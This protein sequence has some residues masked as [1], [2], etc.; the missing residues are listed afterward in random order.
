MET[1][2]AVFIAG[3]LNSYTGNILGKVTLPCRPGCPV[4]YRVFSSILGCFCLTSASNTAPQFW[5]LRIFLTMAKYTLNGRQNCNL[6]IKNHW[7]SGTT[8][9]SAGRQLCIWFHTQEVHT[10]VHH[11]QR[12]HH[13]M[14]ISLSGRPHKVEPA[15]G[16]KTVILKWSLCSLNIYWCSHVLFMIQVLLLLLGLTQ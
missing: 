1:L 2:Q 8:S 12:R 9:P 4:H 14:P 6:L 15:S 3:L 11:T 10:E 7:S 16:P 5:P 13:L